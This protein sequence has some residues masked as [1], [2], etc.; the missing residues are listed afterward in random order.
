M[1]TYIKNILF[2]KKGDLFIEDFQ[3]IPMGYIS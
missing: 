3:L 1:A 2:T